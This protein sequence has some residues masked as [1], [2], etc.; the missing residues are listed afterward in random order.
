V[1]LFVEFY[2]PANRGDSWSHVYIFSLCIFVY[3]GVAAVYIL[4]NLF[5]CVFANVSKEK[6]NEYHCVTEFVTLL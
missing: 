1:V 2:V 3:D 6:K 4:S 5:L